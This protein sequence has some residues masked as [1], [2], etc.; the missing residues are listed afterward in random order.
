M[1]II[2]LRDQ[3]KIKKL[4]VRQRKEVPKIYGPKEEGYTLKNN[5]KILFY[6]SLV[7]IF[8]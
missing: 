5:E 3:S 8:L 7:V 2:E 6:C 1:K 4:Y